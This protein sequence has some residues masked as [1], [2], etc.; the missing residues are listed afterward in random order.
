MTYT[1][2]I[3]AY[4]SEARAAK[5]L[6]MHR[7]RVNRWKTGIPLTAQIQIELATRGRLKADLPQEMRRKVAQPA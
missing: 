6:G 5:E 4:G 7:Q 1:D 3:G 2:L